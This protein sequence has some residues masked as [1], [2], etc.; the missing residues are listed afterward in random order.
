MKS[1]LYIAYNVTFIY[2]LFMSY[3]S[4]GI[5]PIV[6]IVFVFVTSNVIFLVF[7]DFMKKQSE[8][9]EL[10]SKQIK[11]LTQQNDKIIDIVKAQDNMLD[12]IKMQ[13]NIISTITDIDNKEEAKG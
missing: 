2:L 8:V 1:I 12:F 4:L 3:V 10:M 11:N 7:R 9:N 5:F 6:L 13:D